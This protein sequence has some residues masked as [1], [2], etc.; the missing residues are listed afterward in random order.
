MASLR[1]ICR[2]ASVTLL[3][4]T[5]TAQA[6]PAPTP[7]ESDVELAKSHYKTG[8]LNYAA[9]KYADAASEFEE[10]YRLTA[11]GE[12]LYNM[13]KCYDAIGDL[14]GALVAYRKF[15]DTVRAS[16][17]RPFVEKRAAELDKLVAR[18]R[19]TSS[20]AGSNV[21]LDGQRVGTTPLNLDVVEVNPGEHTVDVAAEGYATYHDHMKLE[22]S[23]TKHVDAKLIS[24][25]K[26]VIVE[27]GKVYVPVYKRWYL[28]APIGAV[29]AAGIITGAVLGS[30]AAEHIG[31]D[32]AKLPPVT[33]GASP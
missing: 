4:G 33:T 27:K 10:A 5:L 16:P 17:D 26:T 19:I 15:L 6:Q 11:H 3:L 30:R 31:G 18:I 2:L 14:R 22:L 32:Q 23:Q 8:E 29:V 28:W 1:S 20:V 24:L 13:G 12:L 9:G 25:V 21:M 7:S